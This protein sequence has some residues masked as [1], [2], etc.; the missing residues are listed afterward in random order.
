MYYRN[1]PE[2]L[3]I[4]DGTPTPTMEITP[5]TKPTLYPPKNTKL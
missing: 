5:R 1:N 4:W 2:N 3:Y